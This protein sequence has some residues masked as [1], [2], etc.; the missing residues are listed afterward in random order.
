MIIQSQ[1]SAVAARR[2]H[3]PEVAGSTPALATKPT[4]A[5]RALTEACRITFHRSLLKADPGAVLAGAFFPV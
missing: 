3:T 5:G 4:L 2:V 1:G